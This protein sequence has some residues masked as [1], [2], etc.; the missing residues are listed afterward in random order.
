[1]SRGLG[2]VSGGA[3]LRT[4]VELVVTALA[5]WVGAVALVAAL[6][7]GTPSTDT[8]PD[9]GMVVR[10]FVAGK[11]LESGDAGAARLMEAARG[12]PGVGDVRLS[13]PTRG[14]QDAA[15][16][17]G[18]VDQ[19][20][21]PTGPRLVSILL[22]RADPSVVATL[23]RL[24]RQL[25]INAVTRDPSRALGGLFP[26]QAWNLGVAA[27]TAC[28]C[29]GLAGGLSRMRIRHLLR[30]Q[31]ARLELLGRLGAD[32]ARLRA[33]FQRVVTVGVLIASG[34][35]ATLAV[36]SVFGPVAA[37][38]SEILA[39]TGI[40]IDVPLPWSGLAILAWT[41]ICVLFCALLSRG[42]LNSAL[43]RLP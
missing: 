25:A 29:L 35:G 28:L 43:S 21:P 10:I 9:G 38:V 3:G 24:P 40:S 41:P 27:L 12:T 39:K 36:G 13:S 14:E 33:P 16:D 26:A 23:E 6:A 4:G 17:L 32:E 7:G 42:P 22:T 20:P 34:V 5:S 37:P 8:A 15:R 1:M 19:G 30:S 31:A 18:L 11:G 2:L